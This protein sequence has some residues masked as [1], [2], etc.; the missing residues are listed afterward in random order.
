[1]FS[2]LLARILK[3][4]SAV[5]IA[6]G[7]LLLSFLAVLP[8]I[9]VDLF[10]PLNFPIFNIVAEDPSFSSLEMERQV[11]LPLEAAASGILGVRKVRSSTST[12]IA[13]V[14]VEFGWGAD[15]LRARQLLNEAVAEA[16]TQLPADVDLN[17][18]TLSN[19][20]S[21]IEGYSLSGGR[22]LLKLRDLAAL[23]LKPRLQ[24]LQGV[25]KVR[26]IGGKAQEYAVRVQP[27]KLV[28]YGLGLDD[29]ST[30]LASNNLLGSPGVVNRNAQELALHVNGQFEG[31][32]EIEE[33]VV[34]VKD[35]FPVRVKDLA[36][37]RSAFVP[38][39]GDTSQMGHPSVLIQIYKQPAYD[40]ETVAKSAAEEVRRFAKGLPAGLA[41][42]NYYDQA[43]LVHDSIASVKEAVWI[44]AVL[45]IFVL[46]LFLRHLKT[47]LIA[48]LSIPIS[49]LAALVVMHGLGIGLNIMSL[50]GLAIGTGII[51]DDTIV[52][53]E[54]IFRWLATP[55]LRGKLSHG[56]VI[57]QATQEVVKPVFIS[58]LT[59]IGI[60]LPMIFVEGFA[61]RL[62]A[63]VSWTVTLALAASLLV[64][65]SVIPLLAGKWLAAGDLAPHSETAGAYGAYG[66][67]L[68]FAF[69]RPWL[70][71]I[72][73]F[74]PVA[75]ALT[76]LRRFEVAFLPDLD[77]GALL[78]TTQMPYGTSLPESIRMNSKI[79]AWLAKVP[80]VS[81]VVRRTGHAAGDED[82]DSVSHSDIT[83]KLMP[84]SERPMGL[85][86]LVALLQAK[87]AD[88]PS[89]QV[90]YLMPLAD[91]I[92]DALGGVPADLGVDLYGQ[93]LETLH[94]KAEELQHV[95]EKIP[96]LIDLRP[97]ADS[98]I[99]S[100]DIRV[101]KG[102]AGNLGINQKAISDAL[103]AYTGGLQAT[104]VRQLFREI[105]VTLHLA[106]P[107]RNL[108]LD[109][110]KSLPL[111][112]AGNSTVPL[113]QVA[114]VRFGDI[115]AQI[116]HENLSRKLTL[117][118]NI[119]GRKAQDVAKDV[120]EAINK[121]GLPPGYGWGFSGRYS[122]QQGALR[123]MATVLLLAIFVVAA[124]LWLE[125]R[126]FS[127]VF[128]VLLT[129]PLA[130]VGGILS[131]ALFKQSLNVSS[132]I[133]AVLLV[134]IVVRNGI[135]LLDY[136]NR[137]LA[138]GLDMEQAIREAA[139]KRV[140][141]ILMTAAVTMLGLLPLAVGW[142]T[143]SELQRPLAIA[144]VGGILTSTL[145]TLVVLPA[146]AKVVLRGHLPKPVQPEGDR[147]V[148]EHTIQTEA[149][150]PVRRPRRSKPKAAVKRRRA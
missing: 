85:E 122:T 105:P 131:L 73:A 67:V 90:S 70:I 20:L 31:P 5:V 150:T 144:V 76:S 89:I 26:V 112:T 139:L 104:T 65:L 108:D 133:G 62:F 88:L 12:G 2:R 19:T 111:R 68:S 75:L 72:L 92:N 34:S 10:P 143:G 14:S 125:F 29:L 115:P 38:E 86:D 87:T 99:P 117:S 94:A 54:N 45:V 80:G 23:D 123:N 141:P 47:T 13:M 135:M 27:S 101:K 93:D 95:M 77:E 118:A 110:L 24:R 106:E 74:L 8:A 102:E 138:A 78:L 100:L 15:M 126:S 42:D 79:E 121:L 59:N 137:G 39:R 113:G 97:P 25:Y 55:K 52:V 63:P 116:D 1:M 147:P 35:G 41:I 30:A 127:Q 82:T 91:K 22:D 114:E 124:I 16:K 3:N 4:P 18:E 71:L 50:G 69:R 129:L 40:T 130:A 134:G 36:Q 51:V 120:E 64:S 17:V 44:G 33:T 96:G 60:F 11:T 136:L 66:R 6:V 140:R 148:P 53:L 109:D 48:A 7:L 9:K 32:R 84:K 21:L 46:A 37:V 81:L 145:L 119:K 61:G 107:G 43:L 83:A 57:L 149:P 146:A 98:P 56:E 28:Q 103:Q 49:V 132:M 142:G 128:L 58:T